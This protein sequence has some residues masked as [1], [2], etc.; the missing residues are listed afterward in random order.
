MTLLNLFF[1]T[2]GN[3]GTPHERAKES[4]RYTRFRL[5]SV[6]RFASR[7]DSL[8]S[9]SRWNDEAI[10]SRQSG[11]AALRLCSA[12]DVSLFT[13]TSYRVRSSV[14]PSVRLSVLPSRVRD[15]QT[16]SAALT[17][18]VT[19]LVFFSQI[20]FSV[21]SLSTVNA[22]ETTS[23]DIVACSNSC[24]LAWCTVMYVYILH[25]LMYHCGNDTLIVCVC[26]I[27]HCFFYITD[28]RGEE[29]VLPTAGQCPEY[30]KIK[31]VYRLRRLSL[32][33]CPFF[34][35]FRKK[36]KKMGYCKPFFDFFL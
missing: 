14:R 25:V 3:D 31:F 32:R 10:I 19:D 12:R 7:R 20:S 27:L 21:W 9:M 17:A 24:R 13:C 26:V 8:N 22:N 36:N 23:Y 29:N 33:L 1:E 6:R 16:D 4:N 34:A 30:V 2:P 35:M 5:C 28:H 18:T 11:Y 15:Y